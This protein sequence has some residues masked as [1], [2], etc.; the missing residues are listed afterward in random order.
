MWFE[1]HERVFLLKEV[2]NYSVGNRAVLKKLLS[3]FLR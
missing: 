2:N 3:D 1:Q